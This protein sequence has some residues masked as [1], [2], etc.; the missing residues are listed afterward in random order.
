MARISGFSYGTILQIKLILIH[1]FLIL[2]LF[3]VRFNNGD[4]LPIHLNIIQAFVIL[5]TYANIIPNSQPN[6]DYWFPIGASPPQAFTMDT[7]DQV[8][9]LPDWLKLKMIRSS[10]DRLV[11]AALQELTPDQIVLFVQ[12][13]G[14][15]VTSMSKLLALLDR[16]VIEQLDAV[17]SAVLNT[18]YLAQLIEIQQGRG[19]KNGHIAV[20]ALELH[21][22]ILP[23]Q[24]RKEIRAIKTIS[25]LNAEPMPSV[26]PRKNELEELLDVVLKTKTIPKIHMLRFRKVVTQ[27]TSMRDE[28][29]SYSNQPLVS[30]ILEYLKRIA[31]SLHRQHLVENNALCTLF[32]S[33]FVAVPEKSP[34]FK[35]MLAVIDQF[36][37]GLNPTNFPILYQIL[38]NKRKSFI[39]PVKEKKHD[40]KQQL[41]QVLQTAHL[42]ELEDKGSQLL[43]E[44]T[45]INS[46]S[47][48]LID[49]IS[50]VLKSTEV[51]K[52][53]PGTLAQTDKVGLLVDWL[54]DIDSELVVSTRSH[55]LDLLFNRSL[56]Q[57]RFYLLSLLSHQASW[58]TLH[59][60]INVLLE[61][62]NANYDSTSVLHFIEALICNPKLWQGRDKGTP[63]HE[64][65]EYVLK[66]ND[67]QIAV[68][69]DYILNEGSINLDKLS[70]RV[71]VLLR[72]APPHLFNI[73]DLVY[74]VRDCKTAN[75]DVKKKFLQKLYLNNPAMKFS[76]DDID[77]VY[78]SNAKNLTG[79]D[80]DKVANYTLTAISAMSINRDFQA[81]S[82]NME[83][84]VRKLAAS[85]PSLILRQL[86]VVATLLQGRAHMEY[87][88]LRNQHHMTLFQQVLGLVELLQP[89]IFE[90]VYK[91]ALQQILTCYFHLF[92]NHGGTRDLFPLLCRFLEVLL[93]YTQRDAN[94]ALT[95][96]E[97]H[98]H[99]IQ[100]LSY[101]LKHL[102]P[103]QQILQGVSLLKHKTTKPA[104]AEPEGTF[105][106]EE[107]DAKPST[108]LA[109]STRMDTDN[110]GAAA[111]M[112]TPLNKYQTAPITFTKL[113]N[114]ILRRTGDD[115]LGPLQELETF[116]NKRNF[117]MDAIFERLLTLI[118]SS[119]SG[120]RNS[121]YVLLIRCLKFNPGC[122]STNSH[123]LVIYLACLRDKDTAIALSALEYLT[124]M[125]ICLQEHAA[126]IL[127]DVFEMGIKSK[128]NTYDHIRR[129][130]LALKTQHAC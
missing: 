16:A 128:Y 105:K 86:S 119:T 39:R 82:A 52:P 110:T 15:P 48:N 27:L 69:A 97:Q 99:V 76:V 127:R 53:E 41:A 9:I 44:L 14:T 118:S 43:N 93:A 10:V 19:A 18:V 80:L 8:Q 30:K 109:V 40:D 56:H 65:I 20:Q 88:V 47:G 3:Q 129:C 17:K 104:P 115:V 31:G 125:V 24:P 77:D 83:L 46:D 113:I 95:F 98:T 32:R 73:R 111:V 114:E 12:N 36:I 58:F 126:E 2:L 34:S 51:V 100:E 25:N 130:V 84:L 90:E 66:M 6:L 54:S 61:T 87:Y 106:T 64:Q 101:E 94:I 13:F 117:P 75:E 59:S 116:T 81:M 79:C 38:I 60:T 85:H 50:S 72:C 70:S 74:Y 35:D 112:L 23:D 49:I 28:K 68:F 123:V 55:Q 62:F 78:S 7:R 120:I 42:R 21:G 121:A 89:Q 5:L 91:Q 107:N 33:L 92:N 103:L 1:R 108:S 37:N 63:K 45:K 26:T 11:D 102:A 22:E 29:N 122:I 96:I 67:K 71:E 124:E 57:F 4:E